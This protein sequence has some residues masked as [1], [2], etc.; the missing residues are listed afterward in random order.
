MKRLGVLLLGAA[1]PVASLWAQKQIYYIGNN[2][3]GQLALSA[4][5][6]VFQ[7]AQSTAQAN[8]RLGAEAAK[9]A[10]RNT[11][12]DSRVASATAEFRRD[13][14]RDKEGTTVSGESVHARPLPRSSAATTNSQGLTLST[15]PI[16]FGFM[17]MTHYDQRNA[18]LGNQFSVEPPSQGLAVAN[19]YVV[20]GVNNAFQVYNTSGTPLLPTAIAT[21]QVFG[22]SAAINRTTGANGIYP[23]DVRVIYDQTLNRFFVMQRD[24]DNTI[25]GDPLPSSHLY[26]AVSQTGDPTGNYN[27]YVMNTTD[28]ANAGCPCVADYPEIGADQYGIYISWNEYNSGLEFLDAAVLAIDKASLA[29]N[30]NTPTAVQFIIPFTTGYEFA[31][32]PATTPPGGSYFLNSGG[33]EYFVSSQK[34]ETFDTNVALWAMSNTNSLATPN[35]SLTLAEIVVPTIFYQFPPAVTQ[36]PGPTPLGTSLNAKLELLDG[37]DIRVL[38]LE[39]VTGQLYFMISTGLTDDNGNNVV[40]AAY[41]ILSPIFRGGLLSAAVVNQGYFYIDGNHLLRPAIAMNAQ[42]Q[43]AIVFTLAGPNYYPS[44]AFVTMTGSTVGSTIQMAAPGT[45]PEDG[46][47]GYEAYGGYGV[48]RWGDY[49]AAVVASDG[50]IW[51]GTEYIPNAPRTQLANWGTYLIQYVP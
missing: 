17:G 42:G 41:I 14:I 27:V 39:Y 36:Q 32:Q 28:S 5:V 21:N 6:N 29:S 7:Q 33:L 34:A 26:L 46:F 13:A 31:I 12:S 19:G 40:G 8:A 11:A 45:A 49:S 15:A 23:T 10:N 38:S 2:I 25:F 30:S 37:G 48:A 24:Q 22:V 4:Q 16:G 20:E 9:Q 51:M 43:G 3:T 1:L 35:P 44:A 47:S 50:S 18:N